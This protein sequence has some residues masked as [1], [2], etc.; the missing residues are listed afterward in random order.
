MPVMDNCE[1]EHIQIRLSVAENTTFCRFVLKGVEKNGG[2]GFYFEMFCA[3]I[4]SLP[5]KRRGSSG[6]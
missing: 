3:Y 1:M 6:G 2:K 4:L 5:K